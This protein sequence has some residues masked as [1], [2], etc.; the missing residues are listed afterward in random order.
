[1]ST[2]KSSSSSTSSARASTSGP[3]PP[4]VQTADGREEHIE[5]LKTLLNRNVR[6]FVLDSRMF[7]GTLRCT[8]W[9]ANIVL[10]HTYEYR[11]PT[12]EQIHQ[13]QIARAQQVS[14]V[15]PSLASMGLGSDDDNPNANA[16]GSQA[17]QGGHMSGDAMARALRKGKQN[18][19]NELVD[20]SC[21]YLGM[22]VIPGEAITKLELDEF[23]SQQT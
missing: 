6:V 14:A 12:E 3:A 8:D 15:S 20:M 4:P 1:M 7:W 23:V 21:R 22:V 10:Q 2:S 19:D 9:E 13:Q 11:I 18:D 5:F 16:N 17:N